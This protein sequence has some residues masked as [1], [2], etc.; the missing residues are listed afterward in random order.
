M[1]PLDSDSSCKARLKRHLQEASRSR[2]TRTV[3]PTNESASFIRLW[4]YIT[5]RRVLE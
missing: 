5:K 3:S 2:L 4:F 1:I